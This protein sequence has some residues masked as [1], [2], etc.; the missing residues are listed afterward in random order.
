IDE[1][2]TETIVYWAIENDTVL[3]YGAARK[4]KMDA[5]AKHIAFTSETLSNIAWGRFCHRPVTYAIS[6]FDKQDREKVVSEGAPWI[7]KSSK[8]LLFGET[9]FDEFV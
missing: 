1:K 5:S 3:W 9:R 4:R 8:A 2:G 6:T 7:L